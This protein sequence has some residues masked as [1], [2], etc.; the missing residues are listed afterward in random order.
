MHSSVGWTQLKVS[1]NIAQHRHLK[2]K[3]SENDH[4]FMTRVT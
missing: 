3:H 1:K 2:V 4:I